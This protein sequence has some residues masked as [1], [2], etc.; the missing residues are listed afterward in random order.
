MQPVQR[1]LPQV[2]R[3]HTYPHPCNDHQSISSLASIIY[4]HQING[5][6]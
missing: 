1:L 2:L 6:A 5:A 3:L 4:T